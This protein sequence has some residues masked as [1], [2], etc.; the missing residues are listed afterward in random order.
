MASPY[1]PRQLAH[2]A[3]FFASLYVH[4]RRPLDI[5]AARA[6]LSQRLAGRT[7]RFLARLR[8]D[9]FGEHGNPYRAMLRHAGFELGDVEQIVQKDG[10]EG[11]LD[12]LFR[13]GVY[14]TIDEFK[15]RAPIRR[16]S[17][18][19]AAP[20]DAFRSRGAAHHVSASS[21]GSRG[22][23][24]PVLIDLRF[25]R[26]C[27]ANTMLYLEAWNG[28]GW[29]KGTWEV[30]GASAR[31]RIAKYAAF[32]P[33]PER[34]FSQVDPDDPTLAP[35]FRL[36]TR[37]MLATGRL[38]GVPLPAPEY[39]PPEDPRPVARWLHERLAAGRV[40]HM[41]AFPSSAVALCRAVLRDGIDI[42]G[43]RLT[44]IGEPTTPARLATITR[45]GVSA[46]PRYGSI[47]NGAIGYGCHAPVDADDMH[48]LA[49]Q[50]AVIQAGPAAPAGL[51][52]EALLL[53]S[54][55]PRSPFA[56]L[57]A[58]M[59]DRATLESR[60][61]GCPLERLGWTTHLRSVR[62]YEKLTG[63]GVTFLGGEII[64]ILETVLP[65]RFGGTPIDYQLC[66]DEDAEGQPVL[67]LLVNPS[68]G[69]LDERAVLEVFLDALAA[70]SPVHRLM[71][72]ML[73]ESRSLRVERRPPLSTQA[74]KVLH[75]HL[76]RSGRPR[77]GGV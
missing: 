13:A 31:F 27:A 1:S 58:A 61:C 63:A 12:T 36:N 73:H 53:T 56:L 5:E 38:A 70:A 10:V 30:P 20:T 7:H 26:D 71:E 44:L 24:T 51:P 14:L 11:A 8:R 35:I 65:H 18:E 75:L 47:E 15:G 23:G 67:S 64:H 46:L 34:W 42:A 48:L 6:S 43:A 32:R 60:A 39:A 68:L 69:P 37:A 25:V 76:S 19:L 54:L 62:S 59:G 2:G 29:V 33:P 22:A 4:L 17:L 3:A 16:G 74:G 9:F 45:A 77:A 41:F 66:E 28:L 21:G 55:N 40:P 52:P 72:R 50:H 57:N 49:D